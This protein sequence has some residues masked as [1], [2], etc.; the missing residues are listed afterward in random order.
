MIPVFQV[1][2]SKIGA[3]I[4]GIGIDPCGEPDQLFPAQVHI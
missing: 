2:P 3:I 1:L 4:L